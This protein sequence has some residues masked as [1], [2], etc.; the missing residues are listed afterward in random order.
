MEFSPTCPDPEVENSIP[1]MKVLDSP[2]FLE[3]SSKRRLHNITCEVSLDNGIDLHIKTPSSV[4]FSSFCQTFHHREDDNEEEEE[5]ELSPEASF[6]LPPPP[7]EASKDLLLPNP[8]ITCA[9]GNNVTHS[10]KVKPFLF[11]VLCCNF[12]YTRMTRKNNRKGLY[13]IFSFLVKFIQ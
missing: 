3:T 13:F 8:T 12:Y 6:E 9:V 11:N 1:Q 10:P 4:T 5:E 7:P 2:D